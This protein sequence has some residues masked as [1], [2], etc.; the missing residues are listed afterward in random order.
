MNYTD[1]YGVHLWNKMYPFVKPTPGTLV[2][3]IMRQSC[4]MTLKDYLLSNK[5]N[6]WFYK[7]LGITSVQKLSDGAWPEWLW[8]FGAILYNVFSFKANCWMMTSLKI[9]EVALHYQFKDLISSPRQNFF[10]VI[11]ARLCKSPQFWKK[12]SNKIGT[13]L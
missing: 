2:H 13:C 8:S 12:E 1:C 11:W 3:E 9:F 10:N 5:E 7:E 6:V 4:P